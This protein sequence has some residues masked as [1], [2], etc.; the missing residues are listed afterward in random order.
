[1]ISKLY[2][3]LYIY[4][5]AIL[6]TSIILTI[7]VI[8]VIF[9]LSQR[10]AISEHFENEASLIQRVLKQT[11]EENPANL[12]DRITELSKRLHW[13]IS[14][15]RG[16]SF[17]YY[18]GN[19]PSTVTNK[20]L[21]ELK[22]SQKPI[23][24][25]RQRYPFE[26]LAFLDEKNPDK[27]Y[28]VLRFGTPQSPYPR[29][30]PL[31][32]AG[33]LV[34][35]FLA[36]LLIPYSLYILKP[37]KE[38]MNSIQRVSQGDFSTTVEVPKSSEFRELAEA[39]NN[40]TLKI[41][42]M[43]FQKQRL[44]ADVSH[45]LRS[46]LT[47]MRLGLEILSKDPEGRKKYIQKSI[48]EI[49]HLDKMIQDLLDISKYELD[50]KNINLVKSDINEL[51]RETVEKH[52]LLFEEHRLKIQQDFPNENILVNIDKTLMERALNNI[53]S[54]VVKYAPPD[55]VVEIN[56][57]PGK[58]KILFSIRDHGPGVSEKDREKIFE[59]FYRVDDSRS[60]KTGGTG[61]G[62]SIVRKII[63]LHG[64]RVWAGEPADGQPGL[65]INIE[66][67]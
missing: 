17:I 43:I 31:I 36:L 35:I 52:L 10:N 56:L 41:Q 64:G 4:A 21:D 28:L 42:E 12:Q 7:S 46:P 54:N 57:V 26:Y 3:K 38:M 44:I 30:R 13:N 51:I 22:N 61:L 47:R 59:P 27:G 1:M 14:Y 34:L 11:N 33:I 32:F 9:Q 8:N 16:N 24:L 18:S 39:F 62:L 40:M 29:L 58:D 67:R 63:N 6:I 53:F 48:T 60:R 25:N 65:V 50:T 20:D 55:T 15:W 66:L 2:R 49:E 37:F 23:I 45:E 19:K 5:I